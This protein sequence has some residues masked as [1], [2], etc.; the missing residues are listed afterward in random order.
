MNI[1]RQVD[2]GVHRLQSRSPHIGRGKLQVPNKRGN[3]QIF[4]SRMIGRPDGG[5]DV[6]PPLYKRGT[7]GVPNESAGACNKSPQ[8][9][10]SQSAVKI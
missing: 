2:Q 5:L 10:N 8:K 6:M 7:D 4:N 3:R 1:G 9:F